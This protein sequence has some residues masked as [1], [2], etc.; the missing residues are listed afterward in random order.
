MRKWK[1]EDWVKKHGHEEDKVKKFRSVWFKVV[2][3]YTFRK[4]HVKSTS[5][6]VSSGEEEE[7]EEEEEV[8][9]GDGGTGGARGRQQQHD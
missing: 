3:V 2:Y 4:A 9:G 5:Q 1:E 7:E 6:E 8:G